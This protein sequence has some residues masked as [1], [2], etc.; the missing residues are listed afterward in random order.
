MLLEPRK[1]L[2]LPSIPPTP[3][4]PYGTTSLSSRCRL[5]TPSVRFRPIANLRQSPSPPRAQT[6]PRCLNLCLFSP[7][8][9]RPR[10]LSRGVVRPGA[11]AGFAGLRRC[12]RGAAEAMPPSTPL[13]REAR[14]RRPKSP[15]A[16]PGGARSAS[17]RH[18]DIDTRHRHAA[19]F[20][21]RPAPRIPSG[22][23]VQ[24]PRGP[25]RTGLLVRVVY[26]GR[27]LEEPLSRR[28]RG[29]GEGSAP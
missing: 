20:A 2:H 5:L 3:Q 24:K 26:H 17:H 22:I 13:G 19:R 7:R 12:G 18:L 29:R 15:R 23:A 21:R 25:G 8:C 1:Q 27:A 4:T 16:E 6:Y 9:A 14:R 10:G 11:G 28:E